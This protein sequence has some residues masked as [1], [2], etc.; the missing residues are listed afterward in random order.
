MTAKVLL[1]VLSLL[2]LAAVGVL[3]FQVGRLVYGI[4]RYYLRERKP[5][6]K[7]QHPQLGL[8][9]SDETDETLWTGQTGTEGCK[10]PF[11]LGGS[12][13]GPDQRLVSQLQSILGRFTDLES[14]AIEFLH[15]RESEIRGAQLNL[16][17]LEL[18][19]KQRPKDFTFE[20]VDSANDSRIR[21]VEFV[22]GKPWRAE[23]DD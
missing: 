10:I 21:R 12:A 23:F 4:A 2:L 20:F 8:L 6:R 16:Y 17:L 18:S 19:N 14:Q 22:D 11:L 9:T 3:V 7:I 5:I 1:I 13:D 15:S